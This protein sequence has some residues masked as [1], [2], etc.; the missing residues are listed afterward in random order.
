MPKGQKTCPQCKHN[1]GPRA[2]TCEKCGYDYVSNRKPKE[3]SKHP[4]KTI[5]DLSPK[6][7]PF[8]FVYVPAKNPYDKKK[9][10]CPV[11][12]LGNKEEQIKQW[13][14]EVL[15]YNFK[16]FGRAAKYSKNALKYFVRENVKPGE[17]DNIMKVINTIE[18]PYEK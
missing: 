9:K 12:W 10:L 1:T 8:I 18:S 7:N 11:K 16:L 4:H 6:N 2:L 15:D 13:V 17:F 14:E 5:F 3:P